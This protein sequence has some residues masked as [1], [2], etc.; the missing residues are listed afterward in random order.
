MP[1]AR[2]HETLVY[3]AAPCPLPTEADRSRGGPGGRGV[4]EPAPPGTASRPS[5]PARGTTGQTRAMTGPVARGLA[6]PAEGSHRPPRPLAMGSAHPTVLFE[7]LTRLSLVPFAGPNARA[8]GSARARRT[9]AAEPASARSRAADSLPPPDRSHRPTGEPGTLRTLCR[10]RRSP[11]V[12][13]APAPS[14]VGGRSGQMPAGRRAR[15]PQRPPCHVPR[16]ATRLSCRQ[17]CGLNRAR[18]LG[19]AGGD[20]VRWRELVAVRANIQ[21]QAEGE[22]RGHAAAP[23]DRPRRRRRR[24]PSSS[25]RAVH[26]PARGRS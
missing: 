23:R 18:S 21:G 14:V 1:R 7:P 6:E 26:R 17:R 8:R 9:R 11:A 25:R 15:P 12:E 16:L 2:A 24:P 5:Q 10:T 3:D 19:S 22:I 20:T 4:A 13:P